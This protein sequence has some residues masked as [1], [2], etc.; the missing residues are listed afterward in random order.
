MAGRKNKY[1]SHVQ[2]RLEEIAGW[3]REGLIEAEVCKR[4]GVGVTSF[5]LYKRQYPALLKAIKEGKEIA[6]YRVEDS[7]YQRAMGM[8]IEETHQEFKEGKLVSE[9]KVTKHLAPDPTSMI[10]W[11]KNRKGKQ[12]RD[13]QEIGGQVTILYNVPDVEKEEGDA[14]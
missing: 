5:T 14:W 3:C 12:W 6:D 7:L 9:R 4:L 13:K 10:F 8:D 2:T 11:L 1:Y